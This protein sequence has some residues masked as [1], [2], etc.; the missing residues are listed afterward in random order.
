MRF[1]KLTSNTF[2]GTTPLE[3]FLFI[4]HPCFYYHKWIQDNIYVDTLKGENLSS[5][6]PAT[7]DL[8]YWS[9]RIS[10]MRGDA[11]RETTPQ[12]RLT[13]LVQL[14]KMFVFIVIVIVK[15]DKYVII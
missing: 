15:F 12:G 4:Y 14:L 13:A 5:I 8:I 9:V 7:M 11:F 2:C 3:Y 1:N 10:S 6:Q